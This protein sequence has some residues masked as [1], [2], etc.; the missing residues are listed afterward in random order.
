MTDLP[1]ENRTVADQLWCR[2]EVGGEVTYIN[3]H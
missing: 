2:P 3:S 1:F